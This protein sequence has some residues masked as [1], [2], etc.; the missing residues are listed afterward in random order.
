MTVIETLYRTVEGPSTREITFFQVFFAIKSHFSYFHFCNKKLQTNRLFC[1]YIFRSKSARSRARNARRFVH[2]GGDGSV[3]K[4]EVSWIPVEMET[5]SCNKPKSLEFYVP[6]GLA[7]G[8]YGIVVRTRYCT[9]NRELKV[10]VTAISRP[11]SVAANAA[12]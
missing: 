2:A 3:S 5:V 9:T 8:N 4:D 6:D 12:P 10:P 7:D 1:R 11:V